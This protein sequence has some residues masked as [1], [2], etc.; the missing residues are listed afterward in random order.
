MD[1]LTLGDTKTGYFKNQRESILATVFNV[2]RNCFKRKPRDIIVLKVYT[3]YT[4]SKIYDF[5]KS[6]LAFEDMRCLDKEDI[7]IESHPVEGSN[8]RTP[9]KNPKM[10]T[11]PISPRD[12]SFL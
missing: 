11:E 12:R 8:P 4:E 7:T 2:E 9:L 1:S 3:D 5:S 10:N 6:C